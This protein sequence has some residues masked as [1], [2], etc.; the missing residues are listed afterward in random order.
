MPTKYITGSPAEVTCSHS[1]VESICEWGAGSRGSGKF[2]IGL[3]M[4]LKTGERK[5]FDVEALIGHDLTPYFEALYQ[6]AED[7]LNTL[8]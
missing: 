2:T 5:D 3:T 1:Q 8:K 6:Q 4:V 7:Y